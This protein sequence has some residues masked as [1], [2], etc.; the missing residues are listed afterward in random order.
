M[1]DE[2]DPDAPLAGGYYDSDEVPAGIPVAM[3]PYVKHTRSGKPNSITQE[4]VDAIILNIRSGAFMWVAVQA[5][6]IANETFYKW[7]KKGRGT[8]AE[9]WERPT[10]EDIA[11]HALMIEL[12]NGVEIAKAQ[13]RVTAEQALFATK[14]GVWLRL[15]PGRDLGDPNKPGWTN[16]A[17]QVRGKVTHAHVH[18]LASTEP[19]MDLS[20]LTNEE[21]AALERI[22]AKA[23]IKPKH[24]DVIEASS[25]VDP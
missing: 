5:A 2:F 15:G 24:L 25:T 22:T 23:T 20:R 6:G 7:I 1:D 17:I 12:A 16:P 8:I 13:A 10:S 19:P 11:A 14:P 18:A 3:K 9:G 4:I 21:L